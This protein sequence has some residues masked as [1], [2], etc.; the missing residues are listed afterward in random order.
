MAIEDIFKSVI[1]CSC[2]LCCSKDQLCDSCET[3]TLS[4]N[5]LSK[6][7]QPQIAGLINV[8]P[9]NGGFHYSELYNKLKELSK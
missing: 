5:G 8:W 1:L 2:G 3:A 6:E 7:L 4:A 9:G